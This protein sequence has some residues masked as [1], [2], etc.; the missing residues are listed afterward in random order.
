MAK[1]RKVI[2]IIWTENLGGI[3]KILMYYPVNLKEYEYNIFVLRPRD[4]KIEM[5]PEKY[6]HEKQ[7]GDTKNRKLYS[8][9][10]KYA[11]KNKDSIFHVLN[12][13]P[14]ILS[15]LKMAGCENI[16]YHI[17]GTIYWKKKYLK[18]PTKI[19]WKVAL[20]N[21]IKIIANSEYSKEMFLQRAN[22]K[23]AIKV[24]YNPFE[25]VEKKEFHDIVDKKTGTNL[26]V[27]YVGRM[28]NGK[29]LFLWL[30]IAK[31]LS[32][33]FNDI[34]FHFYGKGNLEKQLKEYVIRLD[35]GDKVN[36]HGFLK[37]IETAYRR[38]DLLMFLS[39]Y[40]SFGNV[41]VE[42]ILQG[43]PVIAKPIPS[44]REIFYDYPEFL[45]DDNRDYSDQIIEKLKN[46]DVLKN[47]AVK[48]RKNFINRF[49]IQNHLRKIAELYEQY[50]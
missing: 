3:E 44:I 12:A 20:S 32:E 43:T 47:E 8:K 15:I 26:S 34:S 10:F 35:F 13:G 49:S 24:I 18:I 19:L 25:I 9:L 30:D 37:D 21:R 36:F 16:I 4:S 50:Q 41:V 42:S 23:Y 31:K 11:R 6:F 38:H 2:F 17:H 28:V 29:N 33:K 48:A 14:I 7:Y 5:F 39:E 22:K 45:L 46:I 1:N 40:E 27:F